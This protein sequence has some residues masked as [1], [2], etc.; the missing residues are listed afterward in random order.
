MAHDI[1]GFVCVCM[2][3]CCVCMCVYGC[4]YVRV[5]IFMRTW[6]PIHRKKARA[7]LF[8]ST[9]TVSYMAFD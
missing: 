9:D 4:M 6:I 3:V 7:G 5:C 8:T 1:Y 2:Y